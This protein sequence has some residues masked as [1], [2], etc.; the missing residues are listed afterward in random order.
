MYIAL[1][2]LYITSLYIP[3]ICVDLSIIATAMQFCLIEEG[4]NV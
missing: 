1:S 2:F 3:H 4:I